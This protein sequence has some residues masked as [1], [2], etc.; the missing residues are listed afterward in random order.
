MT[1]KYISSNSSG[2]ILRGRG[3]FAWRYPKT[4]HAASIAATVLGSN[5]AGLDSDILVKTRGGCGG[6]V[7]KEGIAG[8]YHNHSYLKTVELIIMQ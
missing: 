2:Q 3:G 7:F 1:M 6:C 5:G 8:R 4:L